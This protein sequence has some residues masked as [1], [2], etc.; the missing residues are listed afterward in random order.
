MK[1]IILKVALLACAAI[2]GNV[3]A[4]GVSGQGT[5]E[6]TLQG[7]DLNG[8]GSADAFFDTTLN[9]TWLRDANLNRQPLNWNSAV[10]WASDLDVRGHSAAGPGV[11]LGPGG[12]RLPTMID[13]FTPPVSGPDGCNF[14]FAGGTDCG[15]NVQTKSGTTVY[16]EMAHLFYVTLGN[17]SF[18]PSGNQTCSPALQAGYGLTNTGGFQNMQLDDY[19][20]GLE[21]APDTYR[22]WYFVP[23][24]GSQLQGGKLSGLYAMAVHDGDIGAAVVPEPKTYALMLAGLAVVSAAARRRKAA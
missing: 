20:S 3:H 6:T 9:I 11:W 17:K 5:W 16:S 24:Y 22:A 4:I 2:A 23:R 12:W 15:Y 21:Y 10:A 14:S 13:T 18:C 7:R 8:D 19:W 1:K